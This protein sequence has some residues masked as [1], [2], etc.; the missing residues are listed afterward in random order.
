[1]AFVKWQILILI[2]GHFGALYFYRSIGNCFWFELWFVV[3]L[4]PFVS[5]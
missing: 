3:S 2:I 4:F 5:F 1:M